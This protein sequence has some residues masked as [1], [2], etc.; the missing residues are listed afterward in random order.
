[1]NFH[2][3]VAIG[4]GKVERACQ[5]QL[6]IQN[7]L[8]EA[9][10]AVSD[11]LGQSMKFV[12]TEAVCVAGS[13]DCLQPADSDC[14]IRCQASVGQV[15]AIMRLDDPGVVRS[16]ACWSQEAEGFPCTLTY[17]GRA[18]QVDSAMLLRESLIDLLQSFWF[19]S[20]LLRLLD[21]RQTSGLEKTQ[22]VSAR[23]A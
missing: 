3:A 22:Q 2:E 16:L 9:G 15:L 17:D 12:I 7:L 10:Q 23:V 13:D 4:I 21:G 19:A 11:C 6:E 5:A 8:A 1:M 14:R 20:R 18:V